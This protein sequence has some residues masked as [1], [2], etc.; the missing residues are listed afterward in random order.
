MFMVDGVAK[1]EYKLLY[2]I[3][4]VSCVI[5]FNFSGDGEIY[6]FLETSEYSKSE[7][8]NGIMMVSLM[9]VWVPL[10]LLYSRDV[11]PVDGAITPVR[12]VEL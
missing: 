8:P 7:N 9:R 4:L 10:T 3:S 11:I 12:A 5:S 2:T 6:T 1:S